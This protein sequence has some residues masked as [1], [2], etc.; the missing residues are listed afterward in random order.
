MG[1]PLKF[2]GVGE[3]G[4]CTAGDVRLIVNTSLTDEEI[5]SL[6][7]MSDAEI[8]RELGPQSPSDGA[9]RKLSML[10]TVLAVRTRDPSS[11][12]AG[13]YSE[14]S[15]DVLRVWREE[16][17]RIKRLYRSSLVRV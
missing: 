16:I 3:M 14:E 1:C 10:L 9:I 17:E 5:A 6:I 13:E 15:G 8:D 12:A 4:Y 2:G 11:F 7:E